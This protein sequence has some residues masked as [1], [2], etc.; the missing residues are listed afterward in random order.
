MDPLQ[1]VLQF[2]KEE[3]YHES[4]NTLLKEAEVAYTGENLRPHIIRQNLGEMNMSDQTDALRRILSG[5][6]LT[7]TSDEHKT[8]FNGSP[9]SMITY[10]NHVITAF[11][12]GSLRKFDTSSN[13]V[14]SVNPKLST[15]LCFEESWTNKDYLYFGAMSG[16]VGILNANDMTIVNSVDLPQGSIIAVTLL[17]NYLFVASRSQFVSVLNASDLSHVTTFNY[18][19]PITAMCRINNGVIYSVQND[20]MF[21][22]R[23]IENINEDLLFHMSP[24]A[25]EV[26]ALDIRDLKQCP[27]DET[28]FVALTDRCKAYLYRLA[29]GG[30]SLEVLKVITHFVSDGL[31]QPQLLWKFA[32]TILSTSD[33]QTVV[34]VNV[35]TDSL[36][37]QL[38]GWNKA[39]RCIAIVDDVL[40]VGA[41]DKS[42][43]TYKLSIA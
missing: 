8:A 25:F 19:N 32:P 38:R 30:K 10:G 14:A 3:G 23:S 6:K 34:A 4:F 12:D 27:V 31:T 39:T 11:T 24:N 7:D 28:I 18:N 42:I 37:F 33:D 43:T 36:A 22:F 1:V 21:H 29:P 41:F 26:G 35:E 15:V 20:S 17:D 13:E 2:L 40:F 9:V 16:T 5:K